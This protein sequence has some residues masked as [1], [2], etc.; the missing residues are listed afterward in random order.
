[1]RIYQVLA[2][3]SFVALAACTGAD[4]GDSVAAPANDVSATPGGGET[5]TTVPRNEGEPAAEKQDDAVDENGRP[6]GA[7]D[8]I[9][10]PTP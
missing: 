6:I 2:I 1:M 9:R 10:T 5:S 4:T 8:P 7:T 3:G